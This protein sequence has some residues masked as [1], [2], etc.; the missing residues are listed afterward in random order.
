MSAL[1]ITLTIV[2]GTVLLLGA[3]WLFLIAPRPQKNK[4]QPFLRPYAHRGLWGQEAPENSLRAFDLAAQK[5]FAI[6]L[7]VQLS[8]DGTVMVFHDYTLDRMCGVTGKLAEKTASELSALSLK[9]TGEHIPTL[10]EVLEVVGG[11]VPLLIELKGESGNV[12][13]CPAVAALLSEYRGEWCVESF[14]P[15]LLRWFKKNCPH[16]VRGLLSTNLLREKKSGSKALNFALS[17]A[18]LTFLCRP[19]FHAWDKKYRGRL[20]VCFGIALFGAASFVY[21]VKNEKEYDAYIREGISPIFDEFE[22]TAK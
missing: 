20:G 9:G 17:A 10:R 18:W 14:N 22:P 16:V 3:L 6:E 8:A 19:A 7:D 2:A 12:S 5:G 15:L 13:L 11:R 1:T 21:T 4:I